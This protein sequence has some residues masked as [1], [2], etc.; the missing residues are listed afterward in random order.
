VNSAFL[1]LKTFDTFDNARFQFEALIF[2]WISEA[3]M[4]DYF[5]YCSTVV[6]GGEFSSRRIQI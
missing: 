5:S 1:T 3:V 4:V 2:P 6:A